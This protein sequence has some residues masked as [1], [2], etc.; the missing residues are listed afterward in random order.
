MTPPERPLP[1][2]LLPFPVQLYA[3]DHPLRFGL[4]RGAAVVLCLGPPLSLGVAA[5][6]SGAPD[7][8]G[9]VAVVCGLA[10]TLVLLL[11]GAADV[12]TG[13][14]AVAEI[15]RTT[16]RARFR[17]AQRLVRSGAPGPDARTNLA[18]RAHAERVVRTSPRSPRPVVGLLLVAAAVTGTNA[19]VVRADGGPEFHSWVFAAAC[20][21]L[22]CLLVVLAL[23]ARRRDRALDLL[24]ATDPAPRAAP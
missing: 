13:S 20:V 16:D 18:A 9:A 12:R 17:E 24:I 14:R 7:L 2:H 4:L 23:A 1:G 3:Q 22:V 15:L 10:G 5:V 11:A 19:A 8:P 21:V 6:L